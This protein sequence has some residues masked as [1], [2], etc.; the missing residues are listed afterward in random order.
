M[1]AMTFGNV[2]IDRAVG[3]KAKTALVTLRHHDVGTTGVTPY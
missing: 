2:L 1:F 3:Q